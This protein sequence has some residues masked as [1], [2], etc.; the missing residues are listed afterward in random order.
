VFAS[1]DGKRA[2]K[3]NWENKVR[4]AKKIAELKNMGIEAIFSKAHIGGKGMG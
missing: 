3:K 4:M 2:Q 1:K